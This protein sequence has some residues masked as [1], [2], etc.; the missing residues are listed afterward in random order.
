MIPQQQKA[1]QCKG[2]PI[3]PRNH[4]AVL[5]A[6]LLYAAPV[7]AG[8]PGTWRVDTDPIHLQHDDDELALDV[9]AI[10]KQHPKATIQVSFT[11]GPVATFDRLKGPFRNLVVDPKTHMVRGAQRSGVF[12]CFTYEILVHEPGSQ[13]PRRLEIMID[14]QI[15]NLPPPPDTGKE[16]TGKEKASAWN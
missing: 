10:F 12:G 8:G 3:T 4:P 15:D 16:K 6:K 7:R 1:L 2:A 13:G 9:S 14:P 11:A 5:K